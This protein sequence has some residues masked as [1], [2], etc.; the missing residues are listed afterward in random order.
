MIRIPSG[1][2]IGGRFGTSPMPRGRIELSMGVGDYQVNQQYNTEFTVPPGL[3][4]EIDLLGGHGELDVANIPLHLDIVRVVSISIDAPA[5]GRV[6][7]FGPQGVADAAQLWF[8]SDAG[9]AVGT[10][11]PPSGAEGVTD[12]LFRTNPFGW[13]IDQ[14]NRLLALYNP[15]ETPVS[16]KLFIEGSN[17]SG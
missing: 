15:G 12:L 2:V 4:V 6:L 5:P 17:L 8:Y 1:S 3:Y 7:V 14:G 16:G 13:A 10:G 11:E 9:T